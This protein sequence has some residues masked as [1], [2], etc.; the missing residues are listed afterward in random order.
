MR[1]LSWTLDGN[2]VAMAYRSDL[3]TMWNWRDNQWGVTSIQAEEGIEAVSG[4]S[5]RILQITGL[6]TFFLLIGR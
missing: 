2:Y 6:K 5:Y 3:V 4:F 1:S